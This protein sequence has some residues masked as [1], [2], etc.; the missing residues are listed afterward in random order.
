MKSMA[1]DTFLAT[2]GMFDGVHRGHRYALQALGRE[3]EARG[4]RPVVFTFTQH[5]LSVTAPERAPRLLT[6]CSQRVQLIRSV[7]PEAE[8][9][10]L[11]PADG[12]LGL[13]SRE[14][15]E[16]IKGKYKVGAFAMGFNN[17][18]GRDRATA[19]L[20][21]D[22]P[23]PIVLFEELPDRGISSSAIRKAI[24]ESRFADAEHAL[25]H[26]WQYCGTVVRGKQL[27]RTIGF[28]TA[29]IEALEPMQL[30]PPLGVYAVDV[31]TADG[32]TQRGMAN[33][34]RRPTVDGSDAPI[35]FEVHLFDANPDLYG[36]TLSVRFLS[37][38]RDEKRFDSLEALRR[39][40]AADAEAARTFI[41][42]T[43]SS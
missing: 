15:L 34:G 6:T 13:T 5:P 28:P 37:R 11:N 2:A 27:G 24:D 1:T 40:L 38:L 7:L 42:S 33:I 25:G 43:S 26:I 10:A 8:V 32:A 14:F 12:I 16:S 9:V 18:I 29:N 4:M 31:S 30:L 35:S 19:A 39:Q 20:L 17:H 41:S 23:L 3:A 22:A 21:A 36:Q